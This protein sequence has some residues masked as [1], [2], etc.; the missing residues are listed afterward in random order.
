MGSE[1]GGGALIF[2]MEM[3]AGQIVERSIAGTGNMSVSACV[4]RKIWKMRTGRE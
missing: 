3:Q 2:S 1:R 4:I